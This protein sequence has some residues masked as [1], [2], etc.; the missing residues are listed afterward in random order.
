[1]IFQINT[2]TRFFKAL[3]LQ[4]KPETLLQI[5]SEGKSDILSMQ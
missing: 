1:M 3:V 4:C 5:N 2:T